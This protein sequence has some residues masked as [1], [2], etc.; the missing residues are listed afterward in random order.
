MPSTVHKKVLT[1]FYIFAYFL[2]T[3]CDRAPPSSGDTSCDMQ[4]II[5]WPVYLHI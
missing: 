2:S 4:D 3:R 5:N 1:K